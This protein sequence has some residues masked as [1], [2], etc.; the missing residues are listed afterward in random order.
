MY[1]EINDSLVR[2]PVTVGDEL[3]FGVLEVVSTDTLYEFV[4]DPVQDDVIMIGRRGVA[5]GAEAVEVWL[6]FPDYLR[7]IAPAT[8]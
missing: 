3:I 5:L 4:L 6:N 2:V 1:A 8:R 7:E